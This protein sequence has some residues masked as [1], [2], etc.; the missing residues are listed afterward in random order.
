M[1][2]TKIRPNLWAA[3]DDEKNLYH[4]E[5]ELPGVK[6]TDIDIKMLSGGFMV[7]APK[8]EIEYMGDYAFC[9]PVNPEKTEAEYDNGL[10]TIHVPLKK[11]YEGATKVWVK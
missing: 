8:G 10:L 4:I 11:P 9:C 3:Y 7:K 1:E 6:K 5:I 2:R